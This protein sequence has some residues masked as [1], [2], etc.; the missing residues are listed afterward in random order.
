MK[1][2]REIDSRHSFCTRTKYAGV[3]RSPNRIKIISFFYT[4]Y[5]GHG[6]LSSY[7]VIC[8]RTQDFVLLKKLPVF[9]DF[10]KRIQ[11]Q[12]LRVFL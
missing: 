8:P 11:L 2:W 4:K 3:L 5:K 10:Y 6:T 12:I 1:E 9:S 7:K